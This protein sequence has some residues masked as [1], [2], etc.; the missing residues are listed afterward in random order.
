MNMDRQ[1]AVYPDGL[2][3]VLA[4]FQ[5]RSNLVHYHR[6]RMCSQMPAVRSSSNCIIR[7]QAVTNFYLLFILGRIPTSITIRNGFCTGYP[8]RWLAPVEWVDVHF[9]KVALLTSIVLSIWLEFL[10]LLV[11]YIS[12][13]QCSIWNHHRLPCLRPWMK[14][15]EL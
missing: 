7:T 14:H 15:Q 2:S 6:L 5:N 9:T 4:T 1:G 13:Y 3:Y 10:G 11:I 8:R 12:K